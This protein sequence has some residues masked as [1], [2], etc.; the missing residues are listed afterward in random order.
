MYRTSPRSDCQ[1]GRLTDLQLH[2][3]SGVGGGRALPQIEE[4]VDD[5]VHDGVGAGKD[6]EQILHPLV[7][8]GE[9]LLVDQ[10]PETSCA[11]KLKFNW[12][13][14]NLD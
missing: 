12:L 6:E 2:S 10:K 7:N 1:I 9:R 14:G 13:I 3:S 8:V 5:G 11:I 4:S